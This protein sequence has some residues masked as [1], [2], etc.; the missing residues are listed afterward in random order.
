MENRI[1]S[2]VKVLLVLASL[3]ILMAGI[4]AASDILVPFLLS[5]FIAMACNPLIQW[6]GRYHVPRGISVALVMVFLVII[7]LMLAALVGQSLNDFKGNMPEYKAQLAEQLAWV[8]TQLAALNISVDKEQILSW[9]DP[10]M[11]MG[12]ASNL[13]SGLGSVMTNLLL[14]LLTVV[15][16]MLEADSIP[17]KIHIALDDPAMR[18]KQID[19]FL[20]SVK[21]YLAIKTLVSML[22]GALVGLWVYYLGLEHVMLWAVTAFLFNYIPNIGSIIAA[23]PA[24]LLALVQLGPTTAGLVG[25]GYVVINMVMG[26][27]V[28]PRF[29]GRGLGLSTLMVFLSLIFWGWLLGTVGMLLS[30]PL[31]MMFKMALESSDHSRW[32]ALLLGSDTQS[33]SKTG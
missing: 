25:L 30:V 22:T 7:G 20:D 21:S 15:F 4:K 32:F 12:L 14:I 19:R 5:V 11:L 31:T 3:V 26:N 18:M 24:I 13:L 33:A 28:E 16:M 2:P 23:L 29:M 6:A 9:L 27:L 17:R 10:G 1:S 8:T